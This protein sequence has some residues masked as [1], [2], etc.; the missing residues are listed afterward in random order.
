[1]DALWRTSA[2]V[3]HS[4]FLSCMLLDLNTHSFIMDHGTNRIPSQLA[5]NLGELTFQYMRDIMAYLDWP[6][7]RSA[8]DTALPAASSFSLACQLSAM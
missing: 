5:S 4:A 8:T 6:V 1:M 2:C 7:V 3:V